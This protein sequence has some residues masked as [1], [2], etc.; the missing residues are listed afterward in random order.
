[1]S[2]NFSQKSS[3][4]KISLKRSPLG[5]LPAHRKTVQALG[6]K[7]IRQERQVPSNPAV[8]GMIKKVEYLLNVE[9]V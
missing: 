2:Q 3:K 5:C 7:N 1:M 8:L 4:I 6:L 9:S